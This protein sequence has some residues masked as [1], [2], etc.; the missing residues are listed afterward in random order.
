MCVYAC[1]CVCL[2]V[3]ERVCVCVKCV[4]DIQKFIF[5]IWGSQILDKQRWKSTSFKRNGNCVFILSRNLL[6]LASPSGLY[7]I[8]LDLFRVCLRSWLPKS[9]TRS[10]QARRGDPQLMIVW[11]W[12]LSVLTLICCTL[13]P[14]V[15]FHIEW[16]CTYCLQ[17]NKWVTQWHK[18][19][20]MYVC[21]KIN[22]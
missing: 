6:V 18:K 12:A 15:R 21:K 11:C 16:F 22:R 5:K 14:S 9:I 20:S 1:V 10:K 3:C 4:K 13:C 8:N 7:I 2:W 17:T 19:K